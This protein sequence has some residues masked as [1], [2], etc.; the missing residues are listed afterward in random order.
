MRS[1]FLAATAATLTVVL[2]APAAGT[3]SSEAKPTCKNVGKRWQ[4][5]GDAKPFTSFSVGVGLRFSKKKP[6]LR[7]QWRHRPALKTKTAAEFRR[8]RGLCKRRRDNLEGSGRAER[9]AHGTLME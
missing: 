7:D 1:K 3:T 6:W 4:V 2:A 8:R 5:C 9:P